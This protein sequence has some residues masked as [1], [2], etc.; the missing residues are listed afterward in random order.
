MME[1]I[2][3]N[4]IRIAAMADIHVKETDKGRFADCFKEI[5]TK[6]DVLIIAG[7][8]TDTGDEGEASI[9]IEELKQCTIP[10]LGVLGN[11]DYEKG[12]HKL[13]RQMLQDSGMMILDGESVV[14]KGVGFAG[15]KGFGGGFDK[16]TLSMFGEG[17]MKAFVQEAV[18]EALH[19]E[20]ALAKLDQQHENIKKIAILHYA[21]IYQT[22]VG[23]PEVIYPFLG[24][25][26]LAEPL[27]RHN[28]VA[29]FHGHAHAGTLEGE[30]PGGVKVFNVA[31]PI[32][33]K[34]GYPCGYYTFE[35]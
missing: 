33:K 16:Y 18:D 35:V 10:V 23:E 31:L 27:S 17:A 30:V 22:I 3:E 6:A 28:V 13:I 26:R 21:P 9:L 29:T 8:L 4:K 34:H 20:R 12:R 19:L 11:H 5:S 7:D 2:T 14:V 1:E 25:S 24:S 15:V 32:L